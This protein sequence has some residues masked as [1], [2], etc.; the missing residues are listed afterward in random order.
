M[1]RS[2]I[3]RTLFACGLLAIASVASACWSDEADNEPVGESQD[4]LRKCADG[5]TLKGI[6]I[7]K[8]QET[9]DWKKVKGAGQT[10][11]FSRT[12]DGLKYPDAY[13]TKNWKGMKA[14]GLIRG[15]YQFFRPAQNPTAQAND[16][17][18]RIESAGGLLPGDLPPVL[19]LEVTDGVAKATV[20]SRAKTWI[21]VVE[22]KYKI[23]PLVYTGNNMA[24]VTQS[25]F[26]AYHLWVPN[27]GATCPLMPSGWKNWKFWQ[28]SESGT[29]SGVNG[30]CDTN[31]FNGN[32]TKLKELTVAAP[33]TPDEDA[34]TPVSEDGG[35]PPGEDAGAPPPADEPEMDA[36]DIDLA[37][38]VPDDATMGSGFRR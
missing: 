7:S 36:N 15:A 3:D 13:F 6:D 16:L 8:Y 18:E 34:G 26:S 11:A 37:D 9:V 22:A 14:A 29:V 12:S 20:V 38:Y 35:A 24:S 2:S 31:L 10:F 5:P 23:K 4:E 1:N 27:Y 17:I 28:T 32:V 25:H 19:D 21:K 30:P 33:N